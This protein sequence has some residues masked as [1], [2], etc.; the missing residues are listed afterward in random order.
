MLALSGP[1]TLMF[2]W[3]MLHRL[4]GLSKSDTGSESLTEL[5]NTLPPVNTNLYTL[6]FNQSEMLNH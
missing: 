5:D 1:E 3:R 4:S 6:L 2:Y